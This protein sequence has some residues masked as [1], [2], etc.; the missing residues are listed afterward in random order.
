MLSAPSS[1][2]KAATKFKAQIIVFNI[3]VPITRGFPVRNFKKGF[4]LDQSL[5]IFLLGWVL[6]WY[7]CLNL[8]CFYQGSYSLSVC[9]RARHCEQTSSLTGS[10]FRGDNS[11]EATVS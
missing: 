11:K 3:D 2:V 6:A 1:P 9:Q 10:K 4:R 8:F 7:F 5:L